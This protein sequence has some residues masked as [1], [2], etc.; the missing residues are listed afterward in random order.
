MNQNIYL[1]CVNEKS[2]T[3]KFY[4]IN[5]NNDSVN[6]HYGRIGKTGIRKVERFDSPEQ[7]VKC[8]EKKLKEKIK[9]YNIALKRI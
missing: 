7:A 6:L 8:F 5:L 2:N 9:Y 1:E 3:N 4:E